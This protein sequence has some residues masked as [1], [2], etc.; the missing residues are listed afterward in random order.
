LL[1]KVLRT[2][3]AH[4]MIA[5]GDLVLVALSGGPDSTALLYA[6]AQLRSRLRFRLRAAHVHHGI[7]GAEA[8]A[9]EREAAAFARKLGIPFH[10]HRADIPSYAKTQGLSLEA[11]ARDVR[12]QWLESTA[13]RFRANR[14]AT[15]HTSDDQAETVLLN[16]LRGAGP[17]GLAGIPLVRGRVIRP[18][19]DIT[20][21]DVEAYCGANQ[22]SYRHDTSNEDTAF[23]RNRLRHDIMPALQ[24]IQPAVVANLART[25][26]IMRAE[27]EFMSEQAGNALRGVASQRPGEVGIL[28]S[29]FAALQPALQRRVLRAAIAKVKGDEMDIPLE[30]V[31]ALVRVAITGETGSVVELPGGLRGERTYGELV[32]APA[33]AERATS[34]LEWALPVPGE[35]ALR[36]LGLQLKAS[37]SRAK[38]PPPSPM[39][40]L[41]DAAKLDPPLL[42]RTRRRGD[43]FRPIG[44]RGRAK[45]QDFFVNAK[46]PRAQ[47]DRVPLVLSGDDIIWVVGYRISESFKVTEKTGRSI[48]LEASRLT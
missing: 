21:R 3:E 17:R 37:R 27:D 26:E 33:P 43:R 28:L 44:M 11:A 6:L 18:L 13:N 12:Y 10:R 31:D 16:L 9:D 8:D 1:E 14:I 24:E 25:A 34:A 22:L 29:L 2:I 23:M 38:K 30:R 40:A 5:A 48:R 36:E 47:R 7:R 4:S 39:A 42:V 35:V 19:L 20:R 46:V 45:L 15:G 32:I 41:V